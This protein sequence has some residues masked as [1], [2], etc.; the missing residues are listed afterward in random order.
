[1]KYLKI[2]LITLTAIVI[3]IVIGTVLLLQFLFGLFTHTETKA[4]LVKNVNEIKIEESVEKIKEVTPEEVAT[5]VE[6]VKTKIAPYDNIVKEGEN[7]LLKVTEIVER[8]EK[9]IP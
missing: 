3:L 7:V 9:L 1:M 8:F 5:I 6:Q 2:I 4:E